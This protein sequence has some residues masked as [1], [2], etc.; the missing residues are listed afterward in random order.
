MTQFEFYKSFQ[1][2][3]ELLLA[4]S[5]F[6]YGLRRRSLPLL[7]IVLGIAAVFLFSWWFPIFSND[8][9]YCSFVFLTIFIFT[10]LVCKFIFKET[11]LTVVFCCIAGY[12]AQHLAY[13]V[14]SLTINLM[15]ANVDSPMGFYGSETF[16]GMFSNPF[17]GVVYACTYVGTYFCCFFFFGNKL[18]KNESVKLKT[19][20]I[21]IFVILILLVDI[22]LNSIVVYFLAT[23]GKTLYMIIV[24]V[25]N[26]LCCIIALYLQFEVALRRHLESTLDTVQHLWHMEKEQYELSKENI[27]LI[28]LKCHD[29]KHQIHSLG[30][31]NMVS[32]SVLKEIENRISIYDSVVKTGNDALDVILTEKSLLCNKN[33]VRLSCIVDG[34]KLNFMAEEDIYALFG[35]IIDNAIDAVL[36]LDAAKRVISLHVKTVDDLLVIRS[37]NYYSDDI[38][39]VGGVPQTTKA[40]KQFHGFGIKSIQYICDKYNGDLSFLAENRIFN[41]NILFFPKEITE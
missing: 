31:S 12:T 8:A 27:A 18:R 36:K 5:L 2:V 34:K 20:F 16:S 33:G 37:S 35:N 21:F 14:Y 32:S 29:L 30:S 22:F 38:K 41:I 7:R 26:I 24:S 15:G 13:E 11:W 10:I 17:L 28:N 40:D 25:Y 39:F 19:T 3:W 4:E 6:V 9:F 1:F 23:D